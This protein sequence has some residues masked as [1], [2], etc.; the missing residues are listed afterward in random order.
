MAKHQLIMHDANDA[1]TCEYI[2]LRG[3][4]PN[5][6]SS[7]STFNLLSQGVAKSQFFSFCR[8]ALLYYSALSPRLVD[9]LFSAQSN[10]VAHFGNLGR[11]NWETNGGLDLCLE[12]RYRE[13]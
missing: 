13:P 8:P 2:K 12:F 5:L 4:L 3:G 10:S 7:R 11:A 9:S 6:R 1:N